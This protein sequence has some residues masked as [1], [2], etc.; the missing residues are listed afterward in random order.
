MSS[1]KEQMNAA[2]L[3]VE[4]KSNA[5][6]V[7]TVE[8]LRDSIVDGSPLTGSP[9]QPVDTGELKNSWHTTLPTPTSAIVGTNVVYAPMIEDGIRDIG[10]RR[11]NATGSTQQ[12]LTLRSEVG[13]FHSVKLS[14]AG[15]DRLVAQAV[16]DVG[17]ES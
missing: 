11:G 5:V 8:L 1:F 16:T 9:G 10:E 6:F 15:F 3:K 14:V 2:A 4:T 13:G 7:R 17:G 12:R